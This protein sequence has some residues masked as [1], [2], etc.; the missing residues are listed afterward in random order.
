MQGTFRWILGGFVAVIGLI[1]LF[2]AANGHGGPLETLG[3]ALFVGSIFLVFWLINKSF[4][5]V[6]TKHK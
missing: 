1:S 2:I 5:E 3:I 6:K 4:E